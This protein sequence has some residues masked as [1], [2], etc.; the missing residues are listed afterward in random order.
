MVPSPPLGSLQDTR[1]PAP[2]AYDASFVPADNVI[3]GNVCLYGATSGA[4]GA[5]E[6]GAPPFW[7][8]GDHTP[9]NICRV[10]FVRLLKEKFAFWISFLLQPPN[11]FKMLVR[12]LR[13]DHISDF[14]HTDGVPPL[15]A[16]HRRLST[17]GGYRLTPP[18]P[19]GPRPR[20]VLLRPRR[21]ALLRPE[22]RCHR[23][24]A[25][26]APKPRRGGDPSPGRFRGAGAGRGGG[27]LPLTDARGNGGRPKQRVVIIFKKHHE[28]KVNPGHRPSRGIPPPGAP[29]PRR[30]LGT[31]GAST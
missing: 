4:R 15:P 13:V 7:G 14:V 23:R 31:T 2:A 12:R 9:Q 11:S 3:V 30:G 21:G 18:P 17:G 28:L 27:V 6:G 10:R 24:L 22:L 16:G 5:A 25:R 8:F 20:G 29:R 1:A 26:G 19:A